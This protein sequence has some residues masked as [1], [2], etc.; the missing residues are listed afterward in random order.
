M[1]FTGT[2]TQEGEGTCSQRQ[3][4]KGSA[5]GSDRAGAV[6]QQPCRAAAAAAGLH[7]PGPYFTPHRTRCCCCRVLGVGACTWCAV[8]F[9]LLFFPF[10]FLSVI[11]LSLSVSL[12]LSLSLSLSLSLYFSLSLSPPL[13]LPPSP[14]PP[15]AKHSIAGYFSISHIFFC[16]WKKQRILL[17][18]ISLQ[19]ANSLQAV[20]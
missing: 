3:V 7:T 12:F 17:P 14:S 10:F 6:H 16:Q 15:L 9:L 13:L 4:P 19:S 1:V 2:G 18:W 5:Q 8:F 11:S 20:V